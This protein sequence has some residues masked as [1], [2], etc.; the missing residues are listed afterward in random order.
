MKRDIDKG[1]SM[2]RTISVSWGENGKDSKEKTMARVRDL[3]MDGQ[4]RANGVR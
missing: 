1:P 3:W 4:A 2:D